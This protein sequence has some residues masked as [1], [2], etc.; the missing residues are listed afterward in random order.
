MGSLYYDLVGILRAA[1]CVVNENS[2]TAGW[3]R[4][5]RSSGGFSAPPLGVW[6]HHTASK[7][8]PESD[9]AW[10]INGCPDGPVGNLLLDRTGTY[11]PVAGGAS[12]CAGKGGPW[13]FSRGTAP[14]DQ[15]NTTGFQIE[16]ANNG[17]GEPYP[18]AQVDAFIRGSNALNAHVG[19]QPTDIVSH[20]AWA[21]TRKIDPATTAGV[22][23][24]WKPR[25]C[26]SSGTWHLDDMKSECARR[27]SAD[28][29]GDDMTD[30]QA[31]QLAAVYQQL[32]GPI[33]ERFKD[34]GGA[35]LNV[36]W[37]VGWTW[38]Y[39]SQNVDQKLAE[40]IERLTALEAGG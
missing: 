6:W 23:G 27:A 29:V 18:Q 8:T 25:S 2:T 34:P 4:R 3:E 21:P 9:L 16:C 26:T 33:S 17:V 1:G 40:I 5:A 7:T 24:P 13:T 28:P 14:L 36:P 35:V 22:Q 20:H 39:L 11:W 12:N 38:E 15:G 30:E 10:Q 19:N 31:Q 32:T 37:G